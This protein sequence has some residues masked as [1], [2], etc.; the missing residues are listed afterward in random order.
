MDTLTIR[1]YTTEGTYSSTRTVSINI[2]ELKEWIQENK[3][4][5]REKLESITLESVQ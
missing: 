4:N 5:T 2:D 3:L 1:V